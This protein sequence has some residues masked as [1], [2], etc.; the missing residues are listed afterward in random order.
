ML[1]YS[2]AFPGGDA[3][4]VINAEYRI[5]I[6]K[7]VS[8]SFFFNGRINGALR[9]DQLN[10]DSAGLSTLLQTFPNT[11][12]STH[13]LL[14]PGS[15]FRPRASGGAEIVVQLPI[16]QA[17]FRLYWSYNFLRYNQLIVSPNG[18]FFVS[19]SLRN[20]LPPGVLDFQIVPQLTRIVSNPAQFRYTDPLKTLRFTVSRT[21]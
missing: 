1:S 13:L 2:I 8:F 19:D 11:S 20:S 6:V 12:L 7:P 15:N 3:Q 18:D 10:L 21:F 14:A 4:G 5:P 16:I 9:R 17:P